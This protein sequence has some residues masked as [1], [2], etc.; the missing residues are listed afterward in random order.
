MSSHCFTAHEVPIS[1]HT[2][3]CLIRHGYVR[4]QAGNPTGTHGGLLRCLLPAVGTPALSVCSQ[5][6]MGLVKPAQAALD[7]YP[8]DFT[9]T[10]DRV[11]PDG[12]TP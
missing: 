9:W 4:G 6:S 8:T 12:A 2:N 1:T 11:A 3:S 5:Q 7:S 10:L